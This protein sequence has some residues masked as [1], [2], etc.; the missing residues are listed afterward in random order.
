LQVCHHGVWQRHAA[1]A[2]LHALHRGA[3]P[4]ALHPPSV[5][6]IHPQAAAASCFVAVAA[7]PVILATAT[8]AIVVVIVVVAKQRVWS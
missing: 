8:I 1:V 4:S 7:I 5:R 3:V 6:G 2:R